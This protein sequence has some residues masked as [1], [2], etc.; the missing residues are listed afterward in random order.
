MTRFVIDAF[1]WIEYFDGT[2]RG[3]TVGKIVENRENEIF[4]S[5]VTL[6]EIVSKA[7]R[8][9]IDTKEILVALF[10][11]SKIPEINKSISIETGLFHAEIKKHKKFFGLADAFVVV[12]ARHLNAKILTGD[13]HFKDMK[14]SIII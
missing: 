1:A 8:R 14:E 13:Q 6:A 3:L 7:K 2:E 5:L 10:G 11:L 4:T 12:A 9:G